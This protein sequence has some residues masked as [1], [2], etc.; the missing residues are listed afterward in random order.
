MASLAINDE[1]HQRL[2]KYCFERRIPI[3][4]YVNEM[5]Q[6]WLDENEKK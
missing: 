3:K 5:I 4:K 6:K 2:K 1:I